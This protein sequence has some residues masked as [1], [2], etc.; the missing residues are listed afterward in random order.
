MPEAL[1]SSKKRKYRKRKAVALASASVA[2][3]NVQSDGEEIPA[4][5][6]KVRWE[7]NQQT[8]TDESAVEDT[9][10]S[11]DESR[12]NKARLLSYVLGRRIGMA[13]YDPNKCTIYVLEDTEETPQ[14]DLTK[15]VFEQA[16]PDIVL[17]SSRSEDAFLDIAREFVEGSSSV[18]QIRPHKDFSAVKGIDRLSSLRLLSDL[19]HNQVQVSDTGNSDNVA[20]ISNAYD[21]MA[22]RNGALNDPTTKRWNASIRIFNFASLETSPLCIASVGALLD[23]LVHERAAYDLEN[24]G[25]QGLEV[26]NIEI[27]ALHEVM[28]IN[29]DALLSLQIFQNENHA[30]MHSDKTKEGL[31]LYGILNVTQT[32][33]GRSLMRTWLLRPSL[34]LSVI[35]S[36]HDAVECFLRQENTTTANT[37]HGHLKGIKN[38]PRMLSVLRTGKAKV[39]QWQGLVKFTVLCAMLKETLHELYE[40]SNI[41]IVQKLLAAL[42]ISCFRD[43]GTQINDIINWE[44]STEARRVCVRPHI[45]EE[46]DNRKHVYHGIDTVLSKVAE[47][48]C[49]IIPPD[50]ASSLNI[51][52]FPQLGFLICIP[53]QDE[54]R[55]EA[56]VQVLDGWSF[57]FSSEDH[58][59]FKS[60]EMHDMDAHIGDLHSLIVD[61]E[62]EIIQSLLEEVLI[63]DAAIHHACDVCAELDCLLAFANVSKSYDYR[64]PNMTDDNVIEIIQGRHPL[65]EMVIDTFVP[66]DTR[67]TGGD[68]RFSMFANSSDTDTDTRLDENSL[69][70]WNSILLCTGAN[71]CGKVRKAFLFLL[72]AMTKNSNAEECVPQAD[73]TD[74]VHGPGSIE[75][76]H[77]KLRVEIHRLVFHPRLDGILHLQAIFRIEYSYLGPSSFV[78][79]ESASLGIVDKSNVYSFAVNAPRIRRLCSLRSHINQGIRFQSDLSLS[80]F[81][82][83]Y[84]QLV[85]VR[86]AGSVS[87]HDR[88]ESSLACSPQQYLSLSDSTG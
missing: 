67:I 27:L 17:T 15:M 51:V 30:S 80:Q 9:T 37:L 19:P 38:V 83:K 43:I 77:F 50:Y 61:R 72:D 34:S 2:E 53:M 25:I 6:K 49:Q 66:N 3:D 11:S 20:A 76:L 69:A 36:R 26:E 68:G 85:F 75:Y 44:E 65:Q 10:E 63:H 41:D 22:R 62:L 78:P 70:L 73:R 33:L 35:N 13:Y 82:Q 88:P 42:D 5:A 12:P 8:D 54:W 60:Q 57:Q 47:K 7:A 87:I 18:F 32:A 81:Y 79:A 24:E 14:F 84:A 39:T 55:S 45:D 29:A 86:R 52:Y 23:H 16:S 1:N 40:A 46:L 4:E 59:Y 64:R 74:P 28:Q 48:F 31:S 56:G 21:F 71:A 58:V